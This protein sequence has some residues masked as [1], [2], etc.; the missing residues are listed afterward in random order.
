VHRYRTKAFGPNLYFRENI[1]ETVLE[2]IEPGSSLP[3]GLWPSTNGRGRNETPLWLPDSGRSFFA[4]ALT[5]QDGALRICRPRG[6]RSGLCL[7]CA[8]CSI[9]PFEHVIVSHGEPVHTRGEYV[10]A[11]ERTPW[12]G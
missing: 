11:L 5:A 9:Y 3:G 8:R 1:P 10:R 2:T 4:D 6:T 7:P 12:T